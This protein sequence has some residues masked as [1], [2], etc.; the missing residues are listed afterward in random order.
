MS[1]ILDALK[2]A[3]QERKQGNIPDLESSSPAI[4]E[5]QQS[6]RN[7]LLILSIVIVA[8]TLI[9][10]KPWQ[11]TQSMAPIAMTPQTTTMPS[12]VRSRPAITQPVQ[13]ATETGLQQIT[14]PRHEQSATIADSALQP[15]SEPTPVTRGGVT[16][17]S[18]VQGIMALPSHIR[19]ALPNIQISGHIYDEVPATRMV[20]INGHVKR[21]GRH[22]S[23]NITL[24]SITENGI[25]LNFSGTPFFMNVFDSWPI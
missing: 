8:M 22:I 16:T 12:P 21:E 11:T 23:D 17:N 1:Y 9:W 25:I 10:F 18:A 3:D 14:P 19:D 24:E 4:V 20:I 13:P 15:L 7:S 2:R 6:G 5:Q